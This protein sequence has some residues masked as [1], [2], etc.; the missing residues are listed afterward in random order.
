MCF[1]STCYN[2]VVMQNTLF[3]QKVL[4]VVS[5]IPRGSVLTYG[6]VA[7]LAG[8]PRAQRAVGMIMSKNQD[9]KIP[10]H[11]VVRSDGTIGGYNGIRN[12]ILGK[13]SKLALL[14]KEKVRF[15]K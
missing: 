10:C 14:K 1:Y 9:K 8:K 12:G 2:F 13:D 15:T 3:T 11:R 5:E 6:Q 7:K 4:K